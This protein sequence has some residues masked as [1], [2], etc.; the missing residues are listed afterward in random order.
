MYSIVFNIH[1]CIE[2]IMW[3]FVSNMILIE[4]W[5]H[6]GCPS[7]SVS[8]VRNCQRL[9]AFVRIWAEYR[10][11][12]LIW[13][14]TSIYDYIISTLY[15]FWSMNSSISFYFSLSLTRRICLI[16]VL[17]NSLIWP[18]ITYMLPVIYT[19]LE[20]LYLHPW[21]RWLTGIFPSLSLLCFHIVVWF[22]DHPFLIYSVF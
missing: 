20:N 1:H 5:I 15:G 2:D 11:T 12:V 6:W 17:I 13:Y 9:A 19:L 21:S 16:E 3:M 10:K 8:T 18:S 14:L 22:L 7:L 4:P